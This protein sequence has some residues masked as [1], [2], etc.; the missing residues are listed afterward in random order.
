[1]KSA[2]CCLFQSRLQV[3][4]ILIVIIFLVASDEISNTISKSSLETTSYQPTD[5]IDGVVRVH[6][7]LPRSD[8]LRPGISK[9]NEKEVVINIDLTNLNNFLPLK[10]LSA[11]LN[12]VYEAKTK[13]RIQNSDLSQK[14]I[15]KRV[16]KK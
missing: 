3:L 10:G 13:T 8:H 5:P 15:K 9:I 7:S 1:M 11:S 6:V 2:S 16:A 4:E 14:A 12:H